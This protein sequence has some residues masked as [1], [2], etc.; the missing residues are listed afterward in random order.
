M[1]RLLNLHSKAIKSGKEVSGACACVKANWISDPHGA[2]SESM[3]PSWR[4]PWEHQREASL[5]G[6]PGSRQWTLAAD[7]EWP[8][9]WLPAPGRRPW[10]CPWAQPMSR[11]PR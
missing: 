3:A 7:S 8:A 5:P 1:N 4:L 10:Q 11:C 6:H 9:G 2:V